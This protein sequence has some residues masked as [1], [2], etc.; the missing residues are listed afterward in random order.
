L[1][2]GASG[3]VLREVRAASVTATVYTYDARGR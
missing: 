1:E 2:H 3:Q